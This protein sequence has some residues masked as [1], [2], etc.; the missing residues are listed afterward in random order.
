MT[1]HS[2]PALREKNLLLVAAMLL[3]DTLYSHGA[4]IKLLREPLK[5]QEYFSSNYPEAIILDNCF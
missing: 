5:G 1:C 2:D 4:F 3:C